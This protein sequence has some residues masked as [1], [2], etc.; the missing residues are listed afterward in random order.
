MHE[1][2][3]GLRQFSLAALGYPREIQVVLAVRWIWWFLALFPLCYVVLL[4]V[5][6]LCGA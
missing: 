1:L 4:L 2:E 5:V 6:G 3:V